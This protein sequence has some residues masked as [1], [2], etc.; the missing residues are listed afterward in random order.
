M[1]FESL[2]HFLKKYTTAETDAAVI[3]YF[4]IEHNGPLSFEDLCEFHELSERVIPILLQEK[5]IKKTIRNKFTI[6]HN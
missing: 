1:N 3:I 4:H 5:M 2:E 6:K